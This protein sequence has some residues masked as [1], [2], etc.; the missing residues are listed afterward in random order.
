M[1]NINK[2]YI[3]KIMSKHMK[4]NNME[5]KKFKKTKKRKCQKIAKQV[6][7]KGV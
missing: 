2:L 1:I 3:T 5:I 4:K 6:K 7:N